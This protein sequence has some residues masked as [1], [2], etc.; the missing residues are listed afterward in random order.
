MSEVLEVDKLTFDVR[1]SKRRTTVGVTVERNASLVLH[2]PADFPLPEA[3]PL[4]R[5]KLVWVHQKL[6]NKQ[7]APD[8]GIFRRPEFVDG[9]GFYFLGRH[10]RMKL[11]DPAP[12]E[13]P[14]ETV[15]FLGDRL[16]F[17]RDQVVA[18]T[19]RIAEY[20]TRAA[21]LYINQAVD[22]WM[23]VTGTTPAKFVNVVDLGFRWGSCSAD[24]TLNFHWR[25]I[26]LPP[27]VIDYVVVHE[28]CHLKVR[29][30]SSP[31]WKEVSHALPDYQRH[32]EWLRDRG[33]R[34]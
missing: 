9:E 21:H 25:V 20:Y 30:H 17:R 8:E 22:R 18:G 3:E 10:Y 5:S 14:V 29:D 7:K 33:G 19:K 2:L 31:F 26:Q 28:L 27:P 6:I 1:R 13:G 16:L 32:R 34:L 24:G 4:V 12:E 11:I 23:S 15:R